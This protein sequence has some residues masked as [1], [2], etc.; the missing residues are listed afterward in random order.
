MR[1][2]GER[3]RARARATISNFRN[4]G[5]LH[6]LAASPPTVMGTLSSNNNNDEKTGLHRSYRQ[7][8]E[9]DVAYK[10]K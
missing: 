9:Q 10:V 1:S 4:K 8:M 6:M 3:E 5:I 7:N 2:C